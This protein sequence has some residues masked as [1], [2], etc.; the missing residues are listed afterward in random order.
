MEM[1]ME[2]QIRC[3]TLRLKAK[4]SFPHMVKPNNALTLG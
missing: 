4:F 1:E 2:R 3:D